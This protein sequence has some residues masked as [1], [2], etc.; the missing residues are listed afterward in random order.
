MARK[1]KAE[2]TV[3]ELARRF[4]YDPATGVL[5]YRVSPARRIKVGQVA[6]RLSD[7][8]YLIVTV[9]GKCFQ[10][11]RIAWAIAH[12]RWPKEIDHINGKRDDNRLCNLRECDR[13]ENMQNK[14]RYSSNTS[15]HP[16]VNWFK[17]D[18]RWVAR[19]SVRG[20]RYFLGSFATKN[21]AVAARNA[22]KAELHTF[23]PHQ[24]SA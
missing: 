4:S 15:G 7:K 3:K 1:P 2:K 20:R 17:P 12:G 6:G 9:A 19:I 5:R 16:G 11:H 23:H 18:R 24:R 21:E 10:A 14:V 13:A 22:A 8:G